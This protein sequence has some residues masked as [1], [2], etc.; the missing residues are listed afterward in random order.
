MRKSYLDYSMSVIIGRA[1]PDARDGLKPVHRRILYAM[2]SEGL[3][4]NKRY[5]KCAGVVGEVLKKY[6]P[7][8]DSAVYD[9][10]VRLAQE[11]NLR[12]PLIDGQGNFGSV[13]GDP[14]AAYRYTES[15]LERLADFL[16]AD[17]DKE[18]VEWGPNFDDST[19]E[20]LVLPTRFPN[21]LV[22]GSSGIAVG[23]ATSIPPH[24]MGEV[25]DAAI[26]VIENP[27]CTLPELMR[28]VPGPDFPTAGI[29][30]GRDGIRKAYE[31]GRGN[32][33]VRA[34]ASVEVHPKTERE[35]IVVTEIPYQV[36]KAKLV[37]HI[38]DLVRE[39]KLEGIS[40]LRDESSR[41][42]M[43]VVIEVKRDAVAQVVLN[44]L[45]AHTALQTGFGVTLLAIDGG[46][47]RILNLKQ[48]LERFVAHRRDVVTRRTRFEL[49][50]ARAREH[51][52]LGLQIALDHIDEIIELIKKAENRDAA[53]DGLMTR[54]GLSELQAKA[55]LEM[56]LQRLTGLERQKILDE[57]AEVQKLITRLKEILGSEKVLFEVIVGELREVK[58]LFSDE[59]RTEIQS[60]QADLELED[61]IA[62]EEM[63]VTVSHA[64]YVKRNPVSLYRA[65]RRGGRGKTGAVAREEDFLESLFV[66]STHS[67]L[68]VFSDKGKVYWLKVHAIPQA[69]RSARGKPIVNLVQLSPGEKV[70]AI[71]PV[72]ELPE[73]PASG[74]EALDQE[75]AE[76]SQ[77]A[78]KQAVAATG[79]FVFLATQR[80]LIKKTRLDAFSRPRTAGIIALGIEEGDALIS[81]RICGP[82]A[83][84]LLSTA[85]GMAIRFDESDVRPMGRGAYGVKGI[86]LEDGDQVVSGEVL[87]P[88]AEGEPAPT[89][90]T[91]TANGYGKRTELSEYRVQSRG[92]KGLI[93]I[94]TTE[95]NGPVVSAA[96]VLDSEEVMLITNKGMLIR[97]PA[98]GI[99][100]I[101]R[102]TQG[103]RLITVESREEQ[104]VGVAR[105]AETSPEADQAGV[106]EPAEGAAPVESAPADEPGAE[107]T[108]EGNE[109]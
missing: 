2:H 31:T 88:V 30:L 71:L 48:L 92:G 5:S 17:I 28:F 16:L 108:E 87:A 61:L 21:L 105:V 89:I 22:N 63:V 12:Y 90:L 70:A 99:S 104:V 95:R 44:N 46:Q 107:D 93:T 27:K 23:M 34:R 52:L 24:N 8:G 83:H 51:I 109:E 68:L 40:D 94:K 103:V 32:I 77:Q 25:I 86:S 102:N 85:G 7:H 80:G 11:W 9:A 14:A 39:K 15:R 74:D 91:V 55:I 6:H 4:H 50:Q 76:A 82:G 69:G 38:A 37:E 56:Q 62:E 42:G 49:K 45:Y 84:V 26:H 53:R 19:V 58:Q 57:L 79:E 33:T 1:L 75:A 29:I 98:K 64:G 3:H 13:D 81:A 67:Y 47:P 43:R 72:R 66:A 100:V 36:N 54:F 106:A 96:R 101:G 20:P 41:E 78:E 60:A 10:L 73:P 59:R 97:M 35:S 18:T 65:Q